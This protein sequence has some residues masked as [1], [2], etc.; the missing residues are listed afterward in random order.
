MEKRNN[1][2]DHACLVRFRSWLAPLMSVALGVAVL[3]VACGGDGGGDGGGDISKPSD[4]RENL[5]DN[6]YSV[7]SGR[8][9]DRAFRPQDMDLWVSDVESVLV[10]T[11]DLEDV[12]SSEGIPTFAYV[13]FFANAADATQAEDFFSDEG[14]PTERRGST[15]FIGPEVVNKGAIDA[16]ASAAEG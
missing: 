16:L 7:T 15:L 2:D 9:R 13:Y 1:E 11:Q 6:D 4:V 5:E 14:L 10:V 8:V 12:D 3:S